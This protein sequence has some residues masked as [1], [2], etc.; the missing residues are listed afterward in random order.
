VRSWQAK[1]ALALLA[2][3]CLLP[4]AIGSP[5]AAGAATLDAPVLGS[6]VQGHAK[7]VVVV[8]AGATGAPAGFTVQWMTFADFLANDGRFYDVP[9]DAQS[10]AQFT[11]VPTLNTWDGALTS[12]QLAPSAAAAVEIGDLF[13]ETGVTT[14]ATARL[15]LD[16]ATPYIFRAR[17]NAAEGSDAS[18]WSNVYIVDTALNLN[19]TYTLGFWK[20]HPAAWP[21]TSLT[22]GSVAYDQTQL[23]AILDQPAQ[24]NGLVILAHQLIATLLNVAQGADDDD[25]AA[26][27]ASAHALIGSL[28]V[29]PVGSDSLPSSTTSALTQILD[30]YN[31]GVIGPGHCGAVPVAPTSWS[32][33]KSVYR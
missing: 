22:L 18:E 21:V 16:A 19:C 17:A 11:G 13:D 29:P 7:I 27:I 24:G 12:F 9:N 2:S 30:D 1:S 4:L 3:T 14:S 32:R 31:N 6:Y 15:E 23:L 28:V 25:V 20:N 8:V 10:E 5:R 26:A 33:V